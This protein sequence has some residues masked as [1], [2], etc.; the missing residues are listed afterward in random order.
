MEEFLKTITDQIRCVKARDGVA[1]EIKD[2]ILDQ[3]A[4]YEKSGDDH[5]AA[6]EK[7]VRD[8]G[9]PV[10]IGV[11]LDAVHRPQFDWKMLAL[12]LLLNIAGLIV[13]YGAFGSERFSR[14]CAY[15]VLGFAITIGMCF[16]DYTFIG[17][18]SHIIY[19]AM[20]AVMFL[21]AFT[22]RRINGILPALSSFSYLY[23]PVFA[24]ILYRMRGQ[25][26]GGIVKS[27]LI[28]FFTAYITLKFS[29]RL[30]IGINIFV[31]CMILSVTVILKGWFK[32]SRKSAVCAAAAVIIV[33]A[34]VLAFMIFYGVSY[35][36]GYQ[37]MRLKAVI[38]PAEYANAQGYLPTHIRETLQSANMIGAYEGQV[39]NELFVSSDLMLTYIMRAYGMLAAV[40]LIIALAVFVARAVNITRSQKNQMGFIISFGCMLIP[41]VNCVQGVLENLGY[42]PITTIMM[43][44]VTYGG[45]TTVMYSI[46]IGILLSVHRYEKVC[47]DAPEC[48]KAWNISVRRGEDGKAV[49][50]RL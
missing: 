28:L 22:G 37:A 41:A 34:A 5:S 46:I 45:S 21:C 33:P 39:P 14:Q 40:L 17:R 25:K 35:G 47:A 18:C 31:I 49:N 30:P 3:A 2:H 43:P 20:T 4:A 42:F 50:I 26:W 16:I 6:L 44:F 23:V 12:T 13:M 19:I 48:R 10:E 27:L 29:D 38:N 24:G 15:T 9:D 1:R 7:A 32:V 11:A 8:M 36:S